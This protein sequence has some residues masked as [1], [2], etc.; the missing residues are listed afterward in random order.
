METMTVTAQIELDIAESM[1]AGDKTRTGVLRLLRNAFKNEQIK[2]G[3][4]LTE[5]E[6]LKV[7]QR[8]SKQRRDSIT[9]YNEAHRPE[10]AAVEEGELVIIDTY[11]PE[12]LTEDELKKIVDEVVTGLGKPDASAMGQVIGAVMAKV[13][14]KAEGGAV[15]K[16]V[17]ERLA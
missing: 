10:L 9:A 8:E 6:V 17:R 4:E 13:G 1:K 5:A 7:L 3:R 15:A 16:L 11:L 12:A 2:L 14:A